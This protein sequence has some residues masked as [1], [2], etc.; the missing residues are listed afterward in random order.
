MLYHAGWCKSGYLGVDVFLVISGYLT[1]PKVIGLIG[2][3]RFR[4]WYFLENRLFRLLPVVL[5][6]C[7]LSLAVGYWGMLPGD[8]RYLSEEVMAALGFAENILQ[9]VTTQNYWAAIYHKVLMHTW[10]L[11]VLMQFYVVF[12]A[13]MLIFRKSMRPVLVVLMILSLVLYLL[14]V[15]TIGDKYYLLPYRFFEIAAGGLL[16]MRV[17]KTSRTLS[18]LSLGLLTFM[19]FFG[20]FTIGERA[21]PYNL[22]GGTNTIRESFLPREVI[23]LFTVGFALLFLYTNGSKSKVSRFAGR[24]KV[25]SPLGRMSLSLF[26]WHQPLFA[27]YRYFFADRLS[28]QV[29][30]LAIA[31]T[32]MLS[33]VTYVLL[34]KRIRIHKVS[35]MCMVLLWISINAFALW[36]YQQGGAVRDVPELNIRK[37][38][39]DPKVFER[40][41]DRIYD[42]DKEFS[43]DSTK[44]RILVIGNS[45]ARDFANILLESSHAE[46][47]QLSYCQYITSC[48]L[49]RVQQCDRIYFFGWKHDVPSTIWRNLRPEADVWGIGTKNHGTNNG[50]FYKN[51]H[52]ADYYSQ[53]TAIHSDFHEVN[54]LL[55]D[56]WQDHYIDFL[57][58]TLRPDRTVPVFTP[59][60]HFI[61]YDTFHLTPF[62]ARY[63]ALLFF[64]SD[65]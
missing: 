54:R 39:G 5:I 9:S 61:T 2:E 56:E 30:L 36:I 31:L 44:M 49:T 51:R 10:Y 22:V 34:E 14:P 8:Y 55:H 32:L 1:V 18:Y 6:V 33:M 53:T 41:T 23:L 27:F 26:L 16:T 52:R 24:S 20:A 12:P 62:G 28:C 38:N 45:F 43:A 15:D 17:P 19:V 57:S 4:Y 7:C 46:N 65:E 29:L 59:G 64:G 11:G 60:H 37:G 3:G 42:Y 58:V 21:M 47:I 35:R 48:P 25:L 13:L 40:Y 63:Y 50:M